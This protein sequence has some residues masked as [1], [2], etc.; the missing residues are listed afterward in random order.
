MMKFANIRDRF[1]VVNLQWKINLPL[2]ELMTMVF[3]MKICDEKF[4]FESFL[5][6]NSYFQR[7]N[8]L[9]FKTQFSCS[10]SIEPSDEGWAN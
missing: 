2:K 7:L 4:V 3:S 9:S 6:Q 10:E 8:F 5:L 1:S